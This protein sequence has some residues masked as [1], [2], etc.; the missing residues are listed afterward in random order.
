MLHSA[1]ESGLKNHFDN[2]TMYLV[3][4]KSS[5][6]LP[7]TQECSLNTFPICGS[8]PEPQNTKL[9]WKT[10]SDLPMRVHNY[11]R[12]LSRWEGNSFILWV[13]EDKGLILREPCVGKAVRET[14]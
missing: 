8:F 7:V 12:C 9:T 10:S 11:S 6:E 4:G 3:E 5:E 14:V 2:I 1:E 13:R